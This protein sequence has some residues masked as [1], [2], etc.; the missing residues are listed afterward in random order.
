[1]L[2]VPTR[3]GFQKRTRACFDEQK[4]AYWMLFDVVVLAA[5]A[6]AAAEEDSIPLPGRTVEEFKSGG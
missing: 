6:A 1:M 3:S 5:N 2:V 4:T